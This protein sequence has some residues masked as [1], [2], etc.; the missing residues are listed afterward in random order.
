[1]CETAFFLISEAKIKEHFSLEDKTHNQKN[2][3]L[4]KIF[5]YVALKGKSFSTTKLHI[6]FLEA[7]K[8]SKAFR[9]VPAFPRMIKWKAC[10]RKLGF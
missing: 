5:T 10:V 1:M 2:Y 7:V 3:P 9:K 8:N 6:N 4:N